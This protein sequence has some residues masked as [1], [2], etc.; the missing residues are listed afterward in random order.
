MSA[1]T[2]KV[3]AVLLDYV[4]ASLVHTILESSA[5]RAQLDLKSLQAKDVTRLVIEMRRSI[6]LFVS[7]AGRLDDCMQRIRALGRA[8]A[9]ANDG[10]VVVAVE[11]EE[12]GMGLI[13]TK[14]LMDD[15]D[16]KTSP[17]SGTTITVRKYRE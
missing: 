4:P 8:H 6:R 13:A 11:T 5:S 9:S 10:R 14:R 16:V 15:F 2:D 17:S 12:V 1:T 3:V 7:P